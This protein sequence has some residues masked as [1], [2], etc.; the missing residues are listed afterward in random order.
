MNDWPIRKPFRFFPFFL[1]PIFAVF[2]IFLMI[3]IIPPLSSSK[4]WFDIVADLISGM[5]M[6]TGWIAG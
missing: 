1:F 5:V 4:E 6:Q 2:Y 3:I